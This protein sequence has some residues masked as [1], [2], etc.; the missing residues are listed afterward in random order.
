ML[1]AQRDS[2]HPLLDEP[3][4]T[5]DVQHLASVGAR[6]HYGDTQS[7]GRGR[8]QVAPRPV[9]HLDAV[10]F[11][12]LLEHLVLAIAQAVNGLFVARVIRTAV[13]EFDSPAVQERPDSVLAFLAVD[14][15]P[16]VRIRI[17][18]DE[19]RSGVLGPLGQVGVERR[20]PCLVMHTGGIGQDTVEIEQAGM[21]LVW[22]TQHAGLTLWFRG[23]VL[24][25]YHSTMVGGMPP[26]VSGEVLDFS[27]H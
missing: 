7:R 25:R 24:E 1:F 4:E 22:Q 21:H 10:L 11:E 26:A 6:G 18:W 23:G 27:L 9:E 5:G 19:F 17:E 12:D 20:L 14:V 8:L 16:V 15:F 13:G 2:V 3:L